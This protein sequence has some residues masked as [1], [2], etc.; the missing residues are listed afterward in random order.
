MFLVRYGCQE[1]WVFRKDPAIGR[2]ILGDSSRT[3]RISYE[4]ENSGSSKESSRYCLPENS[5]LDF[6]Q[7]FSRFFFQNCSR[8]FSQNS[9][10]DFPRIS[11]GIPLKI[12]PVI[13]NI[14]SG[15]PTGN[16]IRP[17]I[18]QSSSRSFSKNF[19]CGI[20]SRG[21]PE[22]SS[23]FVPRIFRQEY[24]RTFSW[25]LHGF[26]LKLSPTVPSLGRN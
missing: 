16:P 21:S 1:E 17:V 24:T 2:L 25:V 11:S 20:I 26:L 18:C 4:V 8:D 6:S 12:L 13:S 7:D 10:Q 23:R 22:I 14:L 19:F 3:S 5:F 9:F 15:I